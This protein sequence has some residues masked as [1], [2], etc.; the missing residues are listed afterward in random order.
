MTVRDDDARTLDGWVRAIVEAAGTIGTP[1]TRRAFALA[2][3]GPSGVL[4]PAFLAAEAARTAR[5]DAQRLHGAALAALA[6]LAT[7]RAVLE[8]GPSVLVLRAHGR[9]EWAAQQDHARRHPDAPLWTAEPSALAAYL[10]QLVRE[11]E[12]PVLSRGRPADAA[13]VVLAERLARC[14]VEHFGKRPG[15]GKRGDARR[16][17]F[18]R[19]CDAVEQLR[20]RQGV[21]VS[22]SDMARARGIAR[23]MK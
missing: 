14:Y 6:A 22:I 1:E 15:H 18:D 19:V 17:P 16:T 13:G 8:T 4:G 20:R 21:A 12:T 9:S 10:T 5:Q 11:T 3:I 7:L 2:L 23:A